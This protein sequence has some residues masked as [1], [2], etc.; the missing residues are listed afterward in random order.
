MNDSE[1][2]HASIIHVI[3]DEIFVETKKK[4]NPIYAFF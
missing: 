4:I 3:L 1:Y 2:L